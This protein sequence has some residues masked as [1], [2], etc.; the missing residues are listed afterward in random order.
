M[1][2]LAGMSDF[3]RKLGYSIND[4]SKKNSKNNIGAP[5]LKTL[6]SHNVYYAI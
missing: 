3:G 5:I 4:N 1:T 2:K 6:I